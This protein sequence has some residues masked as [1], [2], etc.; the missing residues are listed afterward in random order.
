MVGTF[1]TVV[2][3]YSS[4]GRQEVVVISHFSEKA[5]MRTGRS[6]KDFQFV[7]TPEVEALGLRGACLVV[8]GLVNKERDTDFERY[9]SDLFT[10]L[11]SQYTP[12]M[13]PQDLILAGFRRLH[14]K[15]G[16]SNHKFPASPERLIKLFL[17]KGTIPSIN[18]AVDIYNCIS[19]E[20]R[21]S[22]GAHDVSQI[23]GSVTLRMTD[24]RER[25]V[26]LGREKPELI[27]AGEYCYVDD[28]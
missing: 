5:L 27:E 16:R 25:F 18:L 17:R 10:Q 20:T 13:I 1:H 2:R 22:L 7:L 3:D 9:K 15:V 24:G 28:S 21:L 4:S 23:N 19:L 14:E 8:E 11:K 12:E 6:L 26:P